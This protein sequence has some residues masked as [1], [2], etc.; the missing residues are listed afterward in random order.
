[1]QTKVVYSTL[2]V[3]WR[4][5]IHVHVLDREN[6]ANNRWTLEV[7]D[8]RRGGS[9]V[10]HETYLEH[11]EEIER[12]I[13]AHLMSLDPSEQRFEGDPR[14]D[15]PRK[16]RNH[17]WVMPLPQEEIDEVQADIAVFEA[18]SVESNGPALLERLRAS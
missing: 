7:Y 11:E 8:L 9:F 15:G 13:E 5:I 10:P 14:C 12:Q 16:K 1:M 2:M 3:L 4:I 6:P 17:E 18:L